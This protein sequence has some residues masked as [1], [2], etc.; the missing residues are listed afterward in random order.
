MRRLVLP[1][2]LLL[3]VALPAACGGGREYKA[4]EHGHEKWQVEWDNCVW[5]ATHRRQDD[6]SYVEVQVPEDK[7]EALAS[8]CM[9][10][11]GYTLKTKD[12]EKKK[13][14]WLWW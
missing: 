14:G 13:S 4:P 8:Q 10:K 11:K 3:L 9:E 6:G 2:A 5:D 7:I 12:D 1:A